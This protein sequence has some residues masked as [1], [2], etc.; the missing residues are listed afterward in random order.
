MGNLLVSFV[1]ATHNRR[2]ILVRT[3]NR[4]QEIEC[5]RT[6]YEI[7]VVDNDS[8]DGTVEAAK[9]FANVV[10]PLDQNLGSCAKALGVDRAAAPFIVFL[11]DDSYPQLGSVARMLDYFEKD[12]GLA[13]AGFTVHLPCGEMESS[14]LP[15][16]FHGCGVGLRSAA[17]REVGNLD[18]AF[19]M[20][21]EEYD[22]CFRLANAEWTP[23]VFD[24][25]HVDHLKTAQT[26]RPERTTYLDTRNNLRLVAR[27]LFGEAAQAYRRDW[28][29][30]YRWIAERECHLEAFARG[31]AEGLKDA[32]RERSGI[33]RRRLRL[34]PFETFFSWQVV[35]EH[36]AELGRRGIRR[37]VLAGFGK[38]VYAFYRAAKRLDLQIIAIA[39]D[40]R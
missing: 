5:P 1:I 11:D 20:Q 18:R 4:L 17:I 16:V 30:R 15:H 26:R 33:E 3:L 21:A 2:E 22:V 34:Q 28:L 38:N 23:R 12:A 10:V 40:G 24:D 19:F 9:P 31:R 35:A 6:N 7:I 8:R 36:M 32:R 29:Q 37:I 13:A 14:A 39:D 25:L 27:Y